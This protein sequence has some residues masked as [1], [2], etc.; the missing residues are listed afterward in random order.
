MR[1]TN[2]IKKTWQSKHV[3]QIISLLS[4]NLLG[5]PLGIITNII[6]TRYL[7]A[8]LFGDYK[9]ICS[10]LNFAAL[11]ASLGFFQA[12]NRA[13]VLSKNK[14][15]TQRYYGALIAI[16][17]ILSIVMSSSLV[18]FSK[19]DHN[20][21]NKGLSDFFIR[22]I[23]LGSITLWGLLYET[24]LPANNQI[25][26]LT[27][28]R[29][30]PKVINII[31]VCLLYIGTQH[32]KWNK[33]L[34]ILLLYN[35]SQLILFLYVIFKI[36]PL[37]K[38]CKGKIREIIDYNRTFGFDVYVGSLCAI[39]F[40]YLTEILISYFGVNNI[41]VGFY[42]LAIA[43][44]QPLSFVPSTIATTHYQSFASLRE[45]PR[46]LIMA[47]ISLSVCSVIA[48][49]LLVPPFIKLCYGNEFAPVIG[50]NFFVCIA[51]FLHGL[52]DFYNRFIQANGYGARLRNASFIVGI[53]TLLGSISLIPK[54][55]AY[56][57][58]YAKIIAGAT[59]LFVIQIYYKRTVKELNHK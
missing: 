50:I 23:P 14:E 40:G 48:L 19:L 37:F 30:Y 7:G 6:V 52:A 12:G 49:W 46:K 21:T 1:I 32:L 47:T 53:A 31:I 41:D 27:K 9:Y 16:L 35:G 29:F 51:A 28:I 15:E 56:G 43:L 33:L 57:A 22:I 45:I 5:I 38:A 44:T 18:L 26:L 4:V 8:Q 20:I 34:I 10:I 13:I 42:S 55:G 54:Y 24:V 11:V 36:N 58:A 59:Y 39:G 25:G 3:K 17:A 2:L